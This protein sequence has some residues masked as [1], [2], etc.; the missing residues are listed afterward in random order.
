VR[1]RRFRRDLDNSGSTPLSLFG[2]CLGCRRRSPSRHSSQETSTPER[3][4]DSCLQWDVDA[5]AIRGSTALDRLRAA[6]EEDVVGADLV[7]R[8]AL[9]VAWQTR[10]SAGCALFPALDGSLTHPLAKQAGRCQCHNAYCLQISL[11]PRDRRGA[12]IR[13]ANG[14]R[15]YYYMH[16]T[17]ALGRR[18]ESRWRMQESV[19]SITTYEVHS[20][21]AEDEIESFSAFHILPA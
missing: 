19:T 17:Q 9:A 3:S 5:L 11:K 16:G 21:R 4:W 7:A 6:T 10:K 15:I 1:R 8:L 20:K 13:S 14:N 18:P 2:H 12:R